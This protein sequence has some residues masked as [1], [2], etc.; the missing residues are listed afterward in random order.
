MKLHS[1]LDTDLYKFST[2]YAYLKKYPSAEG[3]FKFCDRNR[4][5]RTPEFLRKFKETMAEASKLS[6]TDAEYEW[7]VEN[8]PYIDAYYWQLLKTF[9]F[10]PDKITVWLDDEGVLQVEVTDVLWKCTLYEIFVL[11]VVTELQNELDGNRPE[12]V[13]TRLKEKISIAREHGF[14][15]SEFGARRRFSYEVQDAVV[16][17]LNENAR[18]VCVGT[19]N[20]HLA[21]K[22]HMKP[23]GTFP[24][25]WVMFHG[26]Q[27]GYKHANYLALEAWSDV[28]NGELGTALTDTYTSEVFFRNFSMKHA[29]LFDGVRQDSG[30]EYK[31]TDM[32][33]ARYK[34]HKIDPFSKTIIFSNALD[35]PKA[36]KIADYCKGKVK[37][38]FGI[39]TNLS[40]D[41]GF[42]AEN[43]VMK[44]SK[45]RMNK[46]QPWEE[47]IKLSDDFGKHMGRELEIEHAMY[48]LKIKFNTGNGMIG[49]KKT[50]EEK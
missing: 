49:F 8:I 7:C 24:H 6:L 18:D 10:N 14:R 48:E 22:Y 31:Y 3:T 41:T 29:K 30:D 5:K 20:V 17:Y 9:R 42:P 33:I 44:L 50:E 40:N 4:K 47:C 45:C 43:I 11:Y 32:A 26:A 25:E 2:S 21:M 23:M 19:S 34:E 15:F 39:G 35:F 1:I 36:A 37:C 27:F 28:Y 12:Q 46:K 16:G 13:I 38:S